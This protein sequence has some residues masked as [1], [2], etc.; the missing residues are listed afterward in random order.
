M[1]VFNEALVEVVHAQLQVHQSSLS[2]LQLVCGICYWLVVDVEQDVLEAPPVRD[3]AVPQDLGAAV[4]LILVQPS[5]LQLLLFYLRD[6]L[7]H[8]VQLLPDGL[9]GVDL[10]LL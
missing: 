4:P 2:G 3:F 6:N 7:L 5:K 9:L 1:H 10:K 8:F